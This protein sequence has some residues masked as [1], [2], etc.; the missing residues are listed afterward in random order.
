MHNFPTQS[1]VA[2]HMFNRAAVLGS[3]APADTSHAAALARSH[4]V[5]GKDGKVNFAVGTGATITIYVYMRVAQKWLLRDG[6]I[7]AVANTIYSVD[8]PVGC[9][10]FI[11]A[12]SGT[13]TAWFYDEKHI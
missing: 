10:F 13:P 4:G 1:V 12:D 8:A 2:A 6:T 11:V 3:A 5:V 9:P 7:T